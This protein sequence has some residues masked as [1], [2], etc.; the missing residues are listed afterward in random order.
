MSFVQLMEYQT[1]N[2]QDV[3]RLHEEWKQVTQGKRN[4]RRLMLTQHHGEPDRFCELVF[5]DSYE[6]AMRNS[7]LPETKEFAHKIQGAVDGDITYFDLDVVD[8]QS[9]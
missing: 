8:E 4:A 9:L 5:F 1:K 3:Q 2:P 7:E 6:D